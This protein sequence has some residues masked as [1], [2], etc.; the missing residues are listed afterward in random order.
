MKRFGV[1]VY[2]EHFNFAASHFLIFADG[3][4]EELHGH[5]YKVRVKVR[6]E[7][8]PGDMV[9]DFCR[10]KPIVK[11]FCDEVDHFLILPSENERL[12]VKEVDDH[13]EVGFTRTDGGVD[14]FLFPRRDVKILPISNTSTERLAEYLGDQ[15]LAAI[16]ESPDTVRIDAFEIEV[17]EASGQC[18]LYAVDDSH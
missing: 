5:N 13:V 8:G 18:G 15:I 14:R 3:T 7:V 1:R 11:R 17:E 2:K 4:R 16:K 9:I 12:E 10:L 6:G